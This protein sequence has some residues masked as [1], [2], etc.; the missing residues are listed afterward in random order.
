MFCGIWCRRK[1]WVGGEAIFE[2]GGGSSVV[3]VVPKW[4]GRRGVEEGFDLAV[5]EGAEEVE[6]EEFF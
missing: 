6:A 4:T 2:L 5:A 3:E 1:V